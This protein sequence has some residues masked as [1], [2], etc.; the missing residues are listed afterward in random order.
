[1]ADGSRKKP[2]E[3]TRIDT[4]EEMDQAVEE[5]MDASDPPSFTPGTAGGPA[6]S[7]KDDKENNR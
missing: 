7:Q 2:T 1:M 5:S 3:Q 4:E 6:A